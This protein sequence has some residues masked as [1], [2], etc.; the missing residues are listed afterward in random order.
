MALIFLLLISTSSV[1]GKGDYV[2]PLHRVLGGFGL[3]AVS[4]VMFITVRRW[5]KFFVG[6]M[7]YATFKLSISLLLGFTPSVPSIARPRVV[8]LEHLAPTVLALVLCA[9]YANR[10]P[11]TG[12]GVG[13][14]GLV[15]VLS[16]DAT[17]D[18]P[19]PLVAGVAVL[20]LTQIAYWARRVLN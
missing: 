12:E 6:V 9:R 18:S 11:R 19:L 1:V 5:V 10:I 17:Y 7:G 16:F 15:L 8:A 13:L 3:L 2:R 4:T 20:G 14:V